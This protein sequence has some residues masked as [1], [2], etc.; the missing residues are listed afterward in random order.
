MDDQIKMI[1]ASN[2][3]SLEQIEGASQII[4]DVYNILDSISLSIEAEALLLYMSFA[5][6]CVKSKTDSKYVF[7]FF[8]FLWKKKMAKNWMRVE[9]YKY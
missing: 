5:S 6:D 9:N 3:D 1:R 8:K 4:Y 7:K 2:H